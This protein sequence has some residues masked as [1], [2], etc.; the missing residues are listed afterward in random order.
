MTPM[1]PLALVVDTSVAVKLYLKEAL[2]AEALA[3]FDWLDDPATLFHVPDFFYAECAHTF[4]KNVQRGLI[5]AVDARDFLARVGKIGLIRTA[6]SAV[7]EQALD[8]ALTHNISA[9]DACYVALS[10]Q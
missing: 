4:W 5:T 8:L 1:T 6:T 9:Y 3:L 2:T 7:C 10:Q